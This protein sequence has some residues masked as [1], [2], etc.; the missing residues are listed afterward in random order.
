MTAALV[1]R[2]RL[3]EQIRVRLAQHEARLWPSLV[4]NVVLTPRPCNGLYILYGE[5]QH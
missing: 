2:G 1:D 4:V 3:P 5:S